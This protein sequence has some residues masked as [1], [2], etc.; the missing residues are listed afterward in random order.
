MNI[1]ENLIHY[2]GYAYM[3]IFFFSVSAKGVVQFGSMLIAV[4]T[5]TFKGIIRNQ[6]AIPLYQDSVLLS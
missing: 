1:V 6:R 5:T 3:F 2:E 4:G